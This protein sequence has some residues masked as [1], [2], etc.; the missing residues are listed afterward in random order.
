MQRRSIQPYLFSRHLKYWR[1]QHLGELPALELP[2]DR[3]RPLVQAFRG[4][5]YPFVL[6][7]E[8]TASVKTVSKKAGVTLFQ[9]LLAAFAALLGRYSGENTFAIGSVT[10]GRDRPETQPLL[11]Y[12]LNTVVLRADL[13]GNPPFTE[14]MRRMRDVTLG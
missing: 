9:S 11:G 12:F 10:S 14:L 4:S 5:M 8:L 7:R 2:T 1:Q 3:P 13:S 6:S